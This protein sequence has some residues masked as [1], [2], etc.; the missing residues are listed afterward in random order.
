M[1]LPQR[2]SVSALWQALN[3]NP[4]GAQ[5]FKDILAQQQ[6][7]RGALNDM[8]SAARLLANLDPIGSAGPPSDAVH[9][10]TRAGQSLVDQN[11]DIGLHIRRIGETLSTIRKATD[12]YDKPMCPAAARLMGQMV[13]LSGERISVYSALLEQV[14]ALELI[15]LELYEMSQSTAPPSSESLRTALKLYE[16]ALNREAECFDKS[17]MIVSSINL[18]AAAARAAGGIQEM[19]ATF[20]EGAASLRSMAGRVEEALQALNGRL[21]GQP[22]GPLSARLRSVGDKLREVPDLL[23]TGN[24]L[25]RAG[26]LLDVNK[27]QAA[28]VLRE[29]GFKL[30]APRA[31]ILEPQ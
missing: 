13:A 7:Y 14:D 22:P 2:D 24:A 10:L 1:L 27:S 5:L 19:G 4:Q 6:S 16:E 9:Q 30:L 29:A 8:A 18:P 12:R 28:D 3:G 11:L 26:L 20:K 15:G 21:K 23:E 17:A 31:P 25:V